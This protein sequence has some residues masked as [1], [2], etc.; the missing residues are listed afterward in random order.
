M[1]QSGWLW[2]RCVDI[3]I[4]SH[5]PTPHLGGIKVQ[6]WPNWDFSKDAA[7]RQSQP[8]FALVLIRDRCPE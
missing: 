7:D 1:K 8:W 6:P 4:Q 2:L 5:Y 3:E